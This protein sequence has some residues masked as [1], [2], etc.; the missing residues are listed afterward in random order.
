MTGCFA[1]D[2]KGCHMA[3]AFKICQI[4]SSG[5]LDFRNVSVFRS[6]TRAIEA[7]ANNMGII[8]S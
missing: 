8:P 6:R 1:I 4:A 7:Q 2:M 5:G 3:D